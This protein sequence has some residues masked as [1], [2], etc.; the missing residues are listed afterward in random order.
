MAAVGFSVGVAAELSVVGE[1]GVGGLDDP[2]EPEPVGA[3]LA[4]AGRSPLDACVL[5]SDAGELLAHGGVVVAA[6][7]VQ[8]LDV[9]EQP[10]VVDGFEGGLQKADVVAVGTVEEVSGGL[11]KAGWWFSC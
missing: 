6:V 5:D 9:A 1:P 10:G 8:G 7:E 3:P 11:C 2:A 4:C